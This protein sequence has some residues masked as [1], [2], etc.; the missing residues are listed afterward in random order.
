[1]SL[2]VLNEYPHF[3]HNGKFYMYGSASVNGF[4]VTRLF[5][6]SRQFFEREMYPNILK[7]YKIRH[8]IL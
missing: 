5:E 8:R 6:C 2:L 1:M 7:D 4:A 3:Y